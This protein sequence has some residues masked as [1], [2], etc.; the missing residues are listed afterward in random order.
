MG[1][2]RRETAEAPRCPGCGWTDHGNGPSC[3]GCGQER[4]YWLNTSIMLDLDYGF[5]I[6]D[7][8]GIPVMGWRGGHEAPLQ[9]SRLDAAEAAAKAVRSYIPTA[10][11]DFTSRAIQQRNLRRMA[12]RR[13]EVEA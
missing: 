8:A 10:Q 3:A 2:A 6:T 7:N 13:Q 5:T 11:V 9:Y 1:R 12:E 4:R